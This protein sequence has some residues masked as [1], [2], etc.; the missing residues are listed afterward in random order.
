MRDLVVRNPLRAL[1]L[2]A[3]RTLEM[4]GAILSGIGQM[5]RGTIGVRQLAGPIGIGEIAADTFR[6]SWLQ[7]LTFMSLISVNL[8]ILNLL[9]VPVLD[10]GTI[11]LT[12]LEWLRGGPLPARL[13]DFAQALG[14]SVIL[15]L[16]GFAFWNDLSRHW[17]GIMGFL[18]ELL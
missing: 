17:Q 2:G 7:F 9:P 8:A 15:V 13:R 16:M 6:A 1:Q 14:L 10:G 12:A 4:T 18:R 3:E 5:I 11:V